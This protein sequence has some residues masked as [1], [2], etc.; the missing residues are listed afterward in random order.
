M[1]DDACFNRTVAV[2]TPTAANLDQL[3]AADPAA[4]LVGPFA[5][6]DA[7]TESVTVRN[8]FFIPNRYMAILL[9]DH[10]S[11]HQAW[12]RI[13]GFSSPTVWRKSASR[14]STGYVLRSHDVPP[15][16]TVP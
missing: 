7:D 8:A 6:G 2:Q 14:P 3:L 4:E 1:W 16:K 12:Q 13:R 15:T 5:A 10:L 9:D 11:P